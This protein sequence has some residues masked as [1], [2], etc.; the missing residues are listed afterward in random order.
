MPSPARDSIVNSDL[1]ENSQENAISSEIKN[2]AK[3][4]TV[5]QLEPNANKQPQVDIEPRVPTIKVEKTRKKVEYRLKSQQRQPSK[6]YEKL[7]YRP[8]RR[9]KDKIPSAL[10]IEGQCQTELKAQSSG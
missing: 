3:Q 4:N 1:Q 5:I 2:T 10:D 9:I 8:V 7:G 6:V